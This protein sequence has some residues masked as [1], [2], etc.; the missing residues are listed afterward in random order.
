MT[1]ATK[2]ALYNFLCSFGAILYIILL[3]ATVVTIVYQLRMLYKEKKETALLSK[4]GP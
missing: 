2:S 4:G 3:V 1:L